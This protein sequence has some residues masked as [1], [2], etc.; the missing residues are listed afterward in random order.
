MRYLLQQEKVEKLLQFFLNTVTDIGMLDRLLTLAKHPKHA[1]PW[2]EKR[3]EEI[4]YVAPAKYGVRGDPTTAQPDGGLQAALVEAAVQTVS[5]WGGNLGRGIPLNQVRAPQGG[6][7]SFAGADNRYKFSLA[8][9][10]K[11]FSAF[12]LDAQRHTTGTWGSW[13]GCGVRSA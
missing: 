10:L 6:F 12:I 3:A 4:F 11:I 13:A 2:L 1:Y 9:Y 7:P 8:K 5:D